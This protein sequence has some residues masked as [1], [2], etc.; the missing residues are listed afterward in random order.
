MTHSKAALATCLV[1][2]VVLVV[3]LWLGVGWRKKPTSGAH[4]D[5]T[6]DLGKGVTMKLVLIPAG[7]FTMG[8]PK[9]E[10]GRD[11]NEG[12]QR[13]VTITKPFYMGIYEVTQEQHEVV[14]GKNPSKFKGPKKPVQQVSWDDATPFCK[15]LSKKTG[16][17]VRLPTEAEW[18]YACRA[19]SKTAFCFGDDEEQLDDYA[20]YRGF[21]RSKTHPV[22]R[23]KPNAWG[24]YDMHGNV[25]EWCSDWYDP[26]ANAK[27]VDPQ[28]PDSRGFRVYRGGSCTSIATDCR[29]ASRGR[30]TPD[31]RSIPDDREGYW[32][33]CGFR[34][35]VEVN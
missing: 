8:S 6:L 18:E 7:T 21:W 13:E 9:T 17:T 10:K 12:P 28:G 30:G 11:N 33:Y 2:L 15:G 24:L 35:V 23:K 20:W 16:K 29:A 26:Y 14:M 34:V 25:W 31:Y 3:L 19:G 5:L 1:V 27:A 22:G 32:G 4:A